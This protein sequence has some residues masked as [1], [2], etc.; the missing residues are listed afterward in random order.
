MTRTTRQFSVN[1][2]MPIFTKFEADRGI[3]SRSKHLNELLGKYYEN[4]GEV[5]LQARLDILNTQSQALDLVI[6]SRLT[7]I[8]AIA[9]AE[10]KADPEKFREWAD[11]LAADMPQVL[12][13]MV[14]STD[15]FIRSIGKR[16]IAR[17]PLTVEDLTSLASIIERLKD[18][19]ERPGLVDLRGGD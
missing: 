5:G 2:T 18:P 17:D 3:K 11:A 1:L 14:N 4:G 7:I 12:E 13:Y 16:I 8:R 15:Y 6:N 19:G 9:L 10:R